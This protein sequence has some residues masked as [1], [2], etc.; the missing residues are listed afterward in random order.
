MAATDRRLL[1]LVDVQ[2]CT[3]CGWCV[4]SCHLHLLSLETERGVKRSVLHNAGDCTGCRRCEVR[5]P[6]GAITMC[7]RSEVGRVLPGPPVGGGVF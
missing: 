6:F 7:G 2:R 4:G 1:P 5:C 3:G